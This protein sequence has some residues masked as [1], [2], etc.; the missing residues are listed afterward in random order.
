MT[1]AWP[2]STL[3][4]SNGINLEVHEA[5]EGPAVLLLHG[6]PGLAYSWRNQIAPIVDAGFRVIAPNQRGIG[7]SDAPADPKTYSVKNLVRDITSLLD[8]LGI[9]QAVWVGHDWGSMPAWRVVRLD[10]VGLPRCEYGVQRLA[11]P[12][13]PAR[14]PGGARGRVRRRKV[15]S[16]SCSSSASPTQGLGHDFRYDKPALMICAADDWFLPP[17]FTKGMKAL[18]PAGA[19]AWRG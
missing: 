8:A 15:A 2:A 11:A 5:G 10:E 18:L 19:R 12:R 1:I 14:D 9:E 4:A 16:T 17:D 3:I 7:G 13:R 6:F